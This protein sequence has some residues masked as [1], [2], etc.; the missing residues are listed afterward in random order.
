M[1]QTPKKANLIALLANVQNIE[2]S[3]EIGQYY[4]NFEE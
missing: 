3:I 4:L 1:D 2:F